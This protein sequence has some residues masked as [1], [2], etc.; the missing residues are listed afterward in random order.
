[1]ISGG[2]SFVT[3]VPA[4][5]YATYR[6][7]D[8]KPDSRHNRAPRLDR[9]PE[10]TAE[11]YG[12]T[13][14][15]LHATDRDHDRL[16]YYATDLPA[17][18]S[19]DATTGVLTLDP[20]V[21]GP[22]DLTV[23]VTD[24]KAHAETTVHVTVRPHGAPVGAV[25]EAEGYTAQH[26][27]TEGGGNFVESNASASGGR[28]IGW[29]AAGNWLS[30][31]FDAPAGAHR[32]EL[33]VANGSGAAATGAISIRD[34]AGEVLGTATVPDTGGW[35]TYQSVE[36][37]VSL[38]DGDQLVTVYCETGGFNLDYLRLTE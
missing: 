32:L 35:G 28:N 6:W 17:G 9:V 29:T 3:S 5:A 23:T 12:T 31:R 16:A 19:L 21:A 8:R 4:S 30:Y 1:V 2:R 11:Q 37:P 18:V 10:V 38:A 22:Q 25:V 7:T 27:W 15:Q 20:V 24:G 36:L 14:I 34:A 33:R 26:G 13:K